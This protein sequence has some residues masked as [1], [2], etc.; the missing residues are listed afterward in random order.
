[1]T[2]NGP[3]LWWAWELDL[4]HVYLVYRGGAKYLLLPVSLP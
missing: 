2:W 3:K 1:M 4:A